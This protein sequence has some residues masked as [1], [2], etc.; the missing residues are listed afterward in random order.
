M[1]TFK[2]S[3]ITPEKIL[4]DDEAEY[5]G[6]TTETGSIGFEALHA[7]MIAVLKK[8]SDILLR[9]VSGESRSFRISDGILS[10]K[11]NACSITASIK[12]KSTP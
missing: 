7:P 4:F 3:I 1:R 9:N 5:C 10:F 2:L 6:I 8:D 12:T 11:N